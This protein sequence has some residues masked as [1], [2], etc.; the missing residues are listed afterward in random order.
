MAYST[1]LKFVQLPL[2]CNQFAGYTISRSFV[3][4][5]VHVGG[6]CASY[7]SHFQFVST[8]RCFQ[9]YNWLV[10]SSGVLRRGLG[11]LCPSHWRMIL[12]I[13][14][15]RMRQNTV[16]STKNYKKFSGEGPREHSP[17]PRPFPQWG[18]GYSSP[19]PSAP[20]A[21]RPLPF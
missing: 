17:L 15:V 20:S 1:C 12:R 6:M 18:G 5:I 3:L 10:W 7:C 8:G 4:L 2:N 21:P 13:K 19:H 14:R 11:G 9:C 16:F